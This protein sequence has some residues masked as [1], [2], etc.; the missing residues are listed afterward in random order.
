M[1]IFT[2]LICTLF[3]AFTAS[4]QFVLVNSPA[5][6]A[7]SK[8]FS[9]A[10][11]GA[12][13]TSG[14]WTADVVFV[15]DGSASPT[16]G[17]MAATNGAALAGKIALI[18][19][20]SCEF[21]VKCLN[22]EMAGA[23]AVVVFN[24][25]PNAGAGTIV[26]GAGAVGAT[27]TVPAVMLSYED[28]QEIR[29]IMATQTVNMTIGNVQFPNDLRISADRISTMFNGVMPT[30][31]AE[32]LGTAFTPAA[33]VLNRGTNDASN[34][35][36]QAV[37]THTPAGGSAA[38]VYD[39]S[40]D[41]AFLD[42]DSSALIL[43]PEYVPAE[44]AGTYSVTYTV[45]GSVAD[46]PEVTSDNT[47]TTNFVL[48]NNVYCKGRWD[49]ANKRPV[50]TNSYTISGGGNIEFLAGFEVPVGV[51]YK[52]DSIQFL[53]TTNAAS[54]GT[55]GPDVV[56]GYVYEWE[57]ANGD[58]L[59]TNDEIEII[60]FAPVSFT[61][62]S[63]TSEWI[64]ADIYDYLELEPG[65]YVIPDDN[66][67]YFVGVRYEGPFLV[68]FGFDEGYNQTLAV[69]NFVDR[70]ID[71]PYIGINAWSNQKPDIEAGFLFT[72]NRA[73]VATAL[74]LGEAPPSSDNEVAPSN[75]AVTLSPNPTS[76][77]LVVESKLKSA[78]GGIT[79]TIR[80]NNG[81]MV[82][83]SSKTINNDYDKVSFNVS[84]YAAGQY[85]IVITT[86]QGIKAERF[87]VQH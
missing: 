49:A 51:G 74:Y 38:Q 26:M 64:K 41:L 75:V 55:L 20:G 87:T 3:L 48:S 15:N 34:V 78:T 53:V 22:A 23:I 47:A 61:D 62:T 70:D 39:Q 11:F 66:K 2:T 30:E 17:C 19:R 7:G 12:A 67:R 29:A 50:T 18:D 44:G 69:N 8:A 73:S 43:L 32:V 21:G 37:I 5:G 13:L 63:A 40:N 42:N 24:S 16:L 84:Q 10:G 52:L 65:G 54:L 80:D 1:R 86:D 85:F 72:G 58:E 81:R 60:G 76:N 79:Y 9:A 82:Y 68:F 4:A 14:V 35:A 6:I 45:T 56:N 46:S 83:S 71:L 59:V 31:Q 27:V 77:Q 57:D 28:G 25:A 33:N 36:L